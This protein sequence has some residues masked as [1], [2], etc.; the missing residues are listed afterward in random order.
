M[1][2]PTMHKC[3]KSAVVL[4]G[5][6]ATTL[7]AQEPGS[8]EDACRR[9]TLQA[10]EA[11]HVDTLR[12]AIAQLA[13]CTGA[14]EALVAVWK[15]PPTDSVTLRILSG[16]SGNIPDVRILN[17]LSTVAENVSEHPGVRLAAVTALVPLYE[18]GKSVILLKGP[19]ETGYRLR[20]Q[21]VRWTGHVRTEVSQPFSE[22]RRTG[23]LELFNRLATSDQ[24]PTIKG[25]AADLVKLLA[26]RD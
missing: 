7:Q 16:V 6:M 18:D 17:T 20:P 25:V 4:A 15:Q 10:T 23:I 11:R 1:T 19:T 12:N 14:P 21:L 13:V 8:L 26:P 22:T 2:L 9:A 3:C 5:L 24:D